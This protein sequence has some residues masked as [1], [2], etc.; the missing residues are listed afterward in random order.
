MKTFQAL[1]SS[2]LIL[3]GGLASARGQATPIIRDIQVRNTGA[4]IVDPSYVL[5]HASLRVGREFDR[6]AAARDVKA[7]IGTGRFS[8]V[9]VDVETL[10]D[11]V[12]LIYKVQGRQRLADEIEVTGCHHFRV[13]KIREWL[14][15]GPGDVVDEP[16]LNAKAQKVL[17]EYR[18]D[19]YPDASVSWQLDESAAMQGFVH[20]TATIDEGPHARVTKVRFV[21]NRSISDRELRA[22]LQFPAWWNVFRWLSRKDFERSKVEDASSRMRQRYLNRGYLDAQVSAPLIEKAKDGRLTV[23]YTINEGEPYRFG[24]VALAGVTNFPETKILKLIKL[25]P[26]AV[27][28]Q[29]DIEKASQDVRDFYG[30]QGYVPTQVSPVITPDRATG[31]ANLIF[32]VS[33]GRLT[34]IRNVVVRGNARTRDKVIRREILVSPGE[35]LNEVKIRQSERILM[36]LGY[37]STVRTDYLTT[38]DPDERDL[39]FQVEESGKTGQFMVGAGFSSIDRL[40]GFAELT[41]GNF[42]LAAWPPYGGGQK[43]KLSTQYGKKR[44][45]YGISFVEPWFLDRKLN[46]G[47]DLDRTDVD[48]DDYKEQSSAAGIWLRRPLPGANSVKLGYRIENQD[49]TYP[50][51]TNRYVYVDPPHDDYY[52]PT[53]EDRIK[54]TARLSLQHDTR[55]RP[56][57]PTRG[58]SS[59]IF[60]SLSGGPLGFDTDIYNVG[61][62]SAQYVPLWFGHVLQLY[63]RWEVVDTYGDTSDVP[64][65]DRLFIGGGRT[66]RGYD[67]REVGPKAVPANPSATAERYRQTGGQ[68]FALAKVD[69]TV[70]LFQYLRLVAFY[71]IGN[72]WRDAYEFDLGNLASSYGVGLRIDMP[73]FPIAFYRAWPAKKDNAITDEEPWVFWIGL[74]Y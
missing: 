22:D 28:S 7:L 45:S 6:A 47:I 54:S 61:L 73:G 72:V 60:G 53:K 70:P 57:A 19:S 38:D 24:S 33:E 10:D 26:G 58:N 32:T 5:T 74:D 39:V 14:G 12:R 29:D 21:G 1:L 65:A 27:A 69:Y 17:A 42:D 23:T 35:T 63:T 55:N 67:W 62:T 13:S 43:L 30:S 16:L 46:L 44:K 41:L 20:V 4:S 3:L 15:L 11:G 51:D 25:R 36:N 49:V 31:T 2:V 66:I 64:Y 68:S 52:V 59:E 37:F 34:R 71:D 8:D 56:F 40:M 50:V 18:A 9:R 48:Y